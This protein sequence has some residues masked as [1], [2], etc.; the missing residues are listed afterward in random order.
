MIT[1]VVIG[2]L[3][4][5]ASIYLAVLGVSYVHRKS[6]PLVVNKR[7][8]SMDEKNFLKC[9]ERALG[10]E[11]FIMPKVRFLDFCHIDSSANLIVQ[12]NINKKVGQLTADFVLARKKDQSILGIVELEKFDK[13]ITMKEKES[14]EKLV[15]IIC[16]KANL[17]LFY[18]DGRQDYSGIDIRRLITGRRKKAHSKAQH[19]NEPSMVSVNDE[20]VMITDKRADKIRKCPK[21]YSKIVTKMSAKGSDIGEK[22]LMCSKHPYCDYRVSLKEASKLRE[23]QKREDYSRQKAGYKN[24]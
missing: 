23:M 22:Y 16:N 17:K 24:W 8:L 12:R 7:F 19:V 20:S 6:F 9:I 11:F 4:L 3:G 10:D 21:C 1:Y 2:F 14:R 13:N 18:F 5:L 15:R